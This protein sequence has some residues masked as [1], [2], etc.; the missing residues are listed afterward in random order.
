MDWKWLNSCLALK[1]WNCWCNYLQMIQ[2]ISTYEKSRNGLTRKFG[3]FSESGRDYIVS[4]P[5]YLAAMRITAMISFGPAR[6]QVSIWQY[7]RA[8]LVRNCLNITLFWQCSPVATPI[9][10]GARACGWK[11]QLCSC[12]QAMRERVQHSP[13]AGHGSQ[14]NTRLNTEYNGRFT[15]INS[16][17]VTVNSFIVRFTLNSSTRDNGFRGF[18]SQFSTNFHEILHTLFSI[19]IA[20]TRFAKLAQVEL[21]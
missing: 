15:F 13:S 6:R 16:Q 10:S 14:K 12:E 17:K 21:S 8:P 5:L 11:R 20:T 2:N 18:L 1:G 7:W 4:L 9:P 3:H 19:Y